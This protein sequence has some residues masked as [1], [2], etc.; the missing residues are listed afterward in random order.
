MPTEIPEDRAT[1][2]TSRPGDKIFDRYLPSASPE[3]REKAR[4]NVRTWT[5][6]LIKV[7]ARITSERQQG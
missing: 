4:E 2:P 3:E 5:V 7:G 1:T 6:Y